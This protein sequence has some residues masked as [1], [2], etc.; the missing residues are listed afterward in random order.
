[1]QFLKDLIFPG[2]HMPHGYCYLWTP[3]L[4][5]LHVASESLIALPYPSIPITTA[6]LFRETVCVL[7]HCWLLVNQV[8]PLHAMANWM[9][10]FA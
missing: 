2:G 8:P 3:V 9:E 5:E 1:M 7:A 10:K 4:I 6:H